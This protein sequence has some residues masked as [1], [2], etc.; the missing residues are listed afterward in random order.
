MR[1]AATHVG[2]ALG[3]VVM[4]TIVFTAIAGSVETSLGN[5]PLATS[6]AEQIAESMRNGA[7]SAEAS[8]LYAVPVSEVE[9]IDEVQTTAMIDGLHAHGAFGAGFIALAAGIF[10]AA[11]RRTD[12]S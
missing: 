9:Q 8:A 12:S 11:R 1:G 4:T 3:V 7:S 6:Q 10:W 2:T 5:D